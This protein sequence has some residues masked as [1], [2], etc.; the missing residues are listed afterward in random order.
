M[1]DEISMGQLGMTIQARILDRLKVFNPGDPKLKETLLRIGLTLETQI[2]LNIRSQRLID[3]GRLLNSIRHKF[4]TEGGV[5]GVTVGSFGVPYA[6]VHEF[7]YNGPQNVR[8]HIRTVTQAFGKPIEPTSYPVAG[9]TRQ[10]R[11]PARPYMRPALD[12]QRNSILKQM[13]GLL[14]NA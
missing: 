14:S 2:K 13:K 9:F 3:T 12:K 11:I 10:M 5:S 7:G 6:S 4:F 8:G 1:A